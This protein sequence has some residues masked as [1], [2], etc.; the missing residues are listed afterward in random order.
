MR[1]LLGGCLQI[2]RDHIPSRFHRGS[3]VQM[4]DFVAGCR[5]STNMVANG[6]CRPGR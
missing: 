2:F 6:V 5:N 1:S 3:I 4:L